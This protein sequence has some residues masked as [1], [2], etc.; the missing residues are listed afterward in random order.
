M[1]LGS[2]MRIASLIIVGGV[3]TFLFFY[4]RGIESS[5]ER[6]L[7]SNATAREIFRRLIRDPIPA[8][9]TDL[10][11]GGTTGPG[12]RVAL[13]FRAPSLEA[14][15]LAGPGYEA[16]SCRDVYRT[17]IAAVPTPSPFRPPW[18]IPVTDDSTCVQA[19]ARDNAWTRSGRHTTLYV[20]GWVYFSGRSE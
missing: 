6:S 1:Q 9:V 10:Q 4:A 16:V 3:A 14:A 20:D 5:A 17:L 2:A 8:R 7:P 15:G 18:Q 12:Y 13:R 19:H 11:G